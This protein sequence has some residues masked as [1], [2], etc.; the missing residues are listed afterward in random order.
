MRSNIIIA[1]V[2][3]LSSCKEVKKEQLPFYNTPDF[4]PQWLSS[5]DKEYASIHTIAPFS[6]I[7]QH[8]ETMTNKNVEGK[9]YVANFFFTTCAGICPRMMNN[10]KKVQKAFQNDKGVMILSHSVLPETDSAQ[11]LNAYAKRFDIGYNWFLLTGN[12]DAIYKIARQSYFA[13]EETGYNKSSKEFL[14][15]ENCILIDKMGRIRGVYNATLE[16]EMNKL[17]Q[18]IRMLQQGD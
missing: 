7:D 5:T 6:F 15:T 9:I 14:H 10:L 18:H 13:D 4:T 8:G 12:K 17:I 2:F 16:L 11:R 1:I 3:I